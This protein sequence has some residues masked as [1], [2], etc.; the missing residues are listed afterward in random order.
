MLLGQELNKTEAA[1]Y[2][3][4]STSTINNYVNRGWIP[5][6]IKKQGYREKVWLKSDL[7]KFLLK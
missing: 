4:V 3:G 7:N 1:E 6:G 5:E 2:L